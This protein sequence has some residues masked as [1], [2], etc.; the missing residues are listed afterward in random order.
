MEILYLLIVIV[1][2]W[3][4]IRIIKHFES[5][6]S[7]L[8]NGKKSSPSPAFQSPEDFMLRRYSYCAPE[9]SASSDPL[10]QNLAKVNKYNPSTRLMDE[11][12]YWFQNATPRLMHR[13]NCLALIN[14]YGYIEETFW[15]NIQKLGLNPEKD[16]FFQK[17]LISVHNVNS[18]W[19]KNFG[20]LL[21]SFGIRYELLPEVEKILR[22]DPRFESAKNTYDLARF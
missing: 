22:E 2:A 11:M 6:N 3:C 1:G 15:Q 17:L 21:F 20:N 4:V 5:K 18:I 8:R 16:A 12:D 19:N 9:A 13:G 7:L 14:S 10:L